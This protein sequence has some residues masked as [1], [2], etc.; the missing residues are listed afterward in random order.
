[1]SHYSVYVFTKKGGKSVEEL[2]KPFDEN[3]I[4]NPPYVKYT[5]EQVIEKVRKDIEDYKNGRYKEYLENPEAYK[6]R[7]HN[8]PA[9]I[10]YLEEE[11]PKKLKWTDE[12]CYEDEARYYRMDGMVDENGG[13]LSK[14]NPKSKWDW[15]VIGGRWFGDIVTKD[16]QKVDEATIG[17]I[18]KEKTQVPFAFITPEGEWFERG[19]MGWWACVTDEIDKDEWETQYHSYL[20]T[21]SDDIAITLVD[22]H[23]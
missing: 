11:F 21:L 12:E 16:G 17:E 6:E 18:D 7:H 5:K 15:W 13:L 1:M 8:I 10:K 9:H 23:I 14:Y 2:L 20:K 4:I 22:C 19:K 3:I